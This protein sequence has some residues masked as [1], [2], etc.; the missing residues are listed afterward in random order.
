MKIAR[1]QLFIG[2]ISLSSLFSPIVT[3]AH[4]PLCTAGAG[5]VAI[6]AYWIGVSGMTIGVLLGAFAM[7]LGL[8]IARLIKKK[9]ISQQDNVIGVFSWVTTILPLQMILSD[10]TSIYINWIGQ[11]GSLFNRTYPIN[12]FLIGSVIGGVILYVSPPL[13]RVVTE[14]RGKMIPYQGLIITFML[15]I[16][17]SLITQFIL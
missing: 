13:S 15:L 12:L 1:L 7:A 9:Y 4:C 11:Y 16:L 3:F 5:L 6:G 17:T 14:R 10:Y 2:G 8:W